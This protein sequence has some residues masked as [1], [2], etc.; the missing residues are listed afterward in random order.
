MG[1][2]KEKKEEEKTFHTLPE[3]LGSH[4]ERGEVC[5]G[6]GAHRGFHEMCTTTHSR[7]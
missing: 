2:Q 3:G 7:L 5:E 4:P 6:V 1:E